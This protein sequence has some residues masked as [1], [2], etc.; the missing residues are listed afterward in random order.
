[1]L[2]TDLGVHN[3]QHKNMPVSPVKVVDRKQ[4]KR[5]L[6]ED[7]PHRCVECSS[8][9][10]CAATVTTCGQRLA[11]QLGVGLSVQ[12]SRVRSVS[13]GR[14]G[15]GKQTE[16]TWRVWK[17]SHSTSGFLSLTEGMGSA[18]CTCRSS[19]LTPPGKPRALLLPYPAVLMPGECDVT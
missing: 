11:A 13:T 7:Q 2:R 1:M 9:W 17:N 10:Q 8:D 19:I 15:C 3:Q 6:S 5:T 16:H 14:Q 12:T 18:C 4:L